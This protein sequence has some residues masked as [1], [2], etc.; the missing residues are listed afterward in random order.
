MQISKN[1]FKKIMLSCIVLTIFACL[2]VINVQGIAPNFGSNKYVEQ[3]T[4]FRATWV[5]TVSNIDTTPQKGTSPEAINKWKEQYLTILNNAKAA[6]LNTIVFQVRPCNDAFY[7]SKYNPW[8]EFMAGFGV[9]PGWDPLAWMIDV[10]HK[11]GLEYHA[12]LNPY[13]ASVDSLKEA[14]TE[15]DQ[16]TKA[17]QVFDYDEKKIN[18]YKDEYFERLKK[19]LENKNT[20]VD[21]PIMKTGDDLHYNILYGTEDKFIL[22]PASDETIEH[23]EKTIKEIVD[24]Y[25]VDGIHFDDYFYPNDCGYKGTNQEYKSIT[26]FSCEPHVDYQ[27]YLDYK[28]SLTNQKDALS[29]YDWRRENVNNLISH[30]SDVINE[31]NKKKTKHFC[32]FG[33]SPAARYAPDETCPIRGTVNGMKGEGCNNYYSYSDLYADIYKWIKSGWIDY[34]VPQLYTNMAFNASGL[35][36]GSYNVLARWWSNVCKDTKCKLFIGTAAYKINDWAKEGVGDALELYYQLRWNQKENNKIDG[37]CFFTYKNIIEGSGKSYSA[38]QTVNKALWKNFALTPLYDDNTY[39]TLKENQEV[40]ISKIKIEADQSYSIYLD[41]EEKE[42]YKAF[43]V[44]MGDDL[45]T[46]VN[47]STDIISLPTIDK[48]KEYKIISYGFNNESTKGTII[49]FASAKENEK[50]KINFEG[51]INKFYMPGD[52]VEGTFKI[53]DSDSTDFTYVLYLNEYEINMGKVENKEIVLNYK[54]LDLKQ[55]DYHFIL[56]VND[57]FGEVIYETSSYKIGEDEEPPI[58]DPPINPPVD[59]SG[60]KGKNAYIEILMLLLITST[61]VFIKKHK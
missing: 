54:V 3:T 61:I 8:S 6:N 4:E 23:L 58:I 13:R 56:K 46:R 44:Y 29:I 16:A 38:M 28:E 51:T 41:N 47:G 33:I 18:D 42:T 50:P 12:W 27:D 5:S 25:D 32:A 1:I 53:E 39:P 20:T 2:F 11:A 17:K 49:D 52:K 26:Y 15:V 36:S 37:Y 59:N 40:G 45:V 35:P 14:I 43:A 57:G 60:C 55:D 21:N 24:N 7:P 10:T 22:N 34:V 31:A 30:L 19:T 9:D 48:T